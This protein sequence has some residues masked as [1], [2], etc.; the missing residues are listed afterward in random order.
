MS[1]HSDRRA[2]YSTC[3]LDAASFAAAVGF[4][5]ENDSVSIRGERRSATSPSLTSRW[6]GRDTPSRW[7]V[8]RKVF[9]AFGDGS[10]NRAFDTTKG[11]RPSRTR[12]WT[13][14]VTSNSPY[15]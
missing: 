2:S 5:V 14:V 11:T 12:T 3:S 1:D 6:Y 10:V 7:Y 8:M 13:C 15:L 9:N 4:V